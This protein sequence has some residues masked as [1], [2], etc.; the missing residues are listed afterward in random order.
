MDHRAID[1]DGDIVKPTR[2]THLGHSAAVFCRRQSGAVGLTVLF[3]WVLALALQ[4][5]LKLRA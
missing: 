3:L 5:W 2:L 1:V 4:V